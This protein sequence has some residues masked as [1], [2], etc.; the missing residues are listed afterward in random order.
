MFAQ[1]K[2]KT[3]WTAIVRLG[4]FFF[5]FL[6]LEYLFDNLMAAVTDST[7]V[8]RAQSYVLGVSAMGFLAY[9]MLPERIRNAGHRRYRVLLEGA[10]GVLCTVSIMI[11]CLHKNYSVLLLSGCLLFFMLGMTGSAG[12]M[13]MALQKQ[14]GKSLEELRD[15]AE[16]TKGR[17]CHWFTV[18]DLHFLK[19][20]GRISSATAVLGT[21]L[22]IKPVMHVDDEGHLTKV[23]TARGRN[24]SLKALVDHMAETAID[25]AGQTVFISHGDCEG[26]ANRVAEDVKR[27]FG[28][29]TVVLNNV[30]PVIGAHSGPG[31]VALFFLGRHR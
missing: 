29:Q 8:V 15:Y 25:P 6:G 26:D 10:A 12:H 31:T 9:G 21:M 30:G 1:L 16:N 13:D 5:V 22:S 24:A 23:G 4:V 20:G 18:D 2:E 3:V 27:R 11:I 19:R 14:A 17:I 28:V 7:G